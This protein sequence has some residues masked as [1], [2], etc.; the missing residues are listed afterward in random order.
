MLVGLPQAKE[1]P[2]ASSLCGAC[3]EVCPVKIDIPR[4]LLRLRRRIV[5]GDGATGGSS[6][7][8][9]RRLVRRWAGAMKSRQS[10]EHSSR[11]LRLL[12][13]PWARKGRV[14]KLPL[15]VVSRWNRRRDLPTLAS[16]PFRDRWKQE[17]PSR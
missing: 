9:E 8:L 13:R 7:W 10:L 5:E 3:R 15:P 12:Q 2:F 11:L 6:S 14:R 16:Q 4:L 17:P 1:L